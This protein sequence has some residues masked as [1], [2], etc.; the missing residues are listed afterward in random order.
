M[1]HNIKIPDGYYMK[2]IKLKLYPSKSQSQFIDRCIEL[3]RYVYNW[4]L[5][6]ENN[7]YE[8]H[9]KGLSDRSFL[10]RYDI[11]RRFTELRKSEGFEF[12]LEIPHISA[13]NAIGE[14][15]DSSFQRYFTKQC[16]RPRFKS[17]KDT[18]MSFITRYDRMYFDHDKVRIEGLPKDEMIY[19]GYDIGYERQTTPHIYKPVIQRDYLGEYWLT[20]SI[21]EKKS[22]EYF[23]KNNIEKSNDVIGIDLNVKKRFVTSDDEVYYGPDLEKYLKKR[24]KAYKKFKKDIKRQLEMERSNPSETISKSNRMLKREK[25]YKKSCKKI[26]NVNLTFIHTICKIIVMKN[27]KAIVMENISV[28]KLL[29]QHYMAKQLHFA[30]LYRCREIMEKK[31][32]QYGIEFILAPKDFK[33]TQICSNCGHEKYMHSSKKVYKCPHCGLKIDRDLNAALNLKHYG[34]KLIKSNSENYNY[35]FDDLIVA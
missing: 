32:N 1:K 21:L 17:K 3:S 8:L 4:A 14:L 10:S 22:I 18:Y 12:L 26:T 5:E 23:Y 6:Q 24:S 27:P 7:Q 29:K 2:H 33:S 20:F 15:V 19:I 9:Q 16:N 34:E 11:E 35:N 31:C 13:R 25:Q 28:K 30:D